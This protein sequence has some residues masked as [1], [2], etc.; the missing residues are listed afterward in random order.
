MVLKKMKTYSDLLL[1]DE[2]SPYYKQI[3]QTP[4]TIDIALNSVRLL[5]NGLITNLA[6]PHADIWNRTREDVNRFC[7]LQKFNKETL[8]Q[9]RLLRRH[10]LS[11]RQL[12]ETTLLGKDQSVPR[13]QFRLLQRKRLESI[14]KSRSS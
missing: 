10:L 13:L 14:Q 11:R 12:I 6:V 9:Y 7:R 3:F 1:D 4:K 5:Q 2:L 8:S